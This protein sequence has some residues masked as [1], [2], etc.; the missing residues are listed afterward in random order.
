MNSIEQR[1][2]KGQK[3]VYPYTRYD[4]RGGQI[5]QGSTSYENPD[6]WTG[7]LPT[8]I[9]VG[10]V[11]LSAAGGRY[12]SSPF[13]FKHRNMSKLVVTLDGEPIVYRELRCNFENNEYLEAY[14]ALCR[15][16]GNEGNGISPEDY[17]NGNAV[18]VLDLGNLV[19]QNNEKKRTGRLGIEMF[20]SEIL[21]EAQ[22]LVIVGES[23][24]TFYIDKDGK[25]ELVM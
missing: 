20:F 19:G 3:A 24:S 17:L 6:I 7:R 11:N 13:N 14:N 1:F 8:R 10:V 16:T 21:P 12:N 23:D 22:E 5:A 2:K 15:N 18:Y 4:Y 9:Y 25:V